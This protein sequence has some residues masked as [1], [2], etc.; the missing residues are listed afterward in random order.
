VTWRLAGTLPGTFLSCNDGRTFAEADRLLDQAPGARWLAESRV[1]HCVVGEIFA[2]EGS[3]YELYA[4]TVMPNHVHVLLQPW[5]DLSTITRSIKGRTARQINNLLGRTGQRL[6]QDESFDHWIRHRDQ[7]E[8][9][10]RYIEQN[11][12]RAGLAR[13]PEE[14]PYSS[15]SIPIIRKIT[16]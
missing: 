1:A 3:T 13:I 12:V 2:G 16:G 6:W 14:W 4:F 11:P 9:V 10:R 7:F 8:R 15:A 5:A